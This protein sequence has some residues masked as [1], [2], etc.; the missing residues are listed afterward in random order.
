MAVLPKPKLIEFIG[1]F[2]KWFLNLIPTPKNSP[3]GPKNS[4][5]GPKKVQKRSQIQPNQKQNP[6][7][8]CKPSASISNYNQTQL[9]P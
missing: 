7:T 8:G 4:P 9:K 6:A 5:E 2:Q 1:M 3:K